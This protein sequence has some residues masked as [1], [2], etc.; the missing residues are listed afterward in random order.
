MRILGRYLRDFKS[1]IPSRAMCDCR[2][3]VCRFF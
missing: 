2:Y 1:Y 3:L